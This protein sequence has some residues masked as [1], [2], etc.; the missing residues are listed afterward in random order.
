MKLVT[1]LRDRKAHIGRLE[2][3]RVYMT[4]WP[5]DVL[6]LMERGIKPERT[7]VHYTLDEVTLTLP[8]RPGKIIGIGRNYAAHAAELNHDVPKNPLV[9]AKFINSVIGPNEAITWDPAL[10]QQVD[11]E[12]ELAVIIGKR[13][14]HVREADAYAHIFGY[15]IANDVSARDL[16][17]AEPQWLRAKGLDTFCPL[18]PCIVTRDALPDPHALSITTQVNGETMQQ[19]T[20]DLMLFRIPQLIAFCSQAFTLEPGDVLLTGT[21]AGVGSGQ[22]PPRFLKDGDVVSI[23]IEGIGTLTNPCRTVAPS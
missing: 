4:N 10:T 17:Q 2:G 23:T 21:P 18:G 13:A 7:S 11:W 1:Y 3:E 19:A 22:K 6:S 20:T 12:G 15:T 8:L 9:F 5:G 14:R 16:Q